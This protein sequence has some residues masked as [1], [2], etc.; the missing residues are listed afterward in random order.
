VN[1][2]T[3]TA[4]DLAHLAL[5]N[6]GAFTS[7]QVEDGAVR[8]LDLHL[9][10]LE[11]WAVELFGEPVGEGR[12][13]DLMRRAVGG[14]GHCGLRVNLFAPQITIRDAGWRGRPSVLTTVS[15]PAAPMS[16]ALCL[17]VQTYAREAAHLKHVA[18]FGLVRAR[19]R[20]IDESHDDVLFIDA[21]GLVSEGSIWNIGFLKSDRVIWPRAP[22]LA[23]TGQALIERGLAGVGLMFDTREVAIDEVAAFDGAFICNSAIPAAP[24]ASIGDQ[25][26]TVDEDAMERLRRAWASNPLQTI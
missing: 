10:R 11:A 14:Q 23:G 26:F 7:M 20:A 6:Y 19:R 3:A 8:G 24:V 21:G 15:P 4:A 12:L 13:R 22:M 17:G 2:E 16:K 1:G 9:T 5:V 25:T 18:T